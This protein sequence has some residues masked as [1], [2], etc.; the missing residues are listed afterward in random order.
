MPA[1]Q[2]RD[3][4]LD[5]YERLKEQAKRDRRSVSQEVIHFVETCL[6]DLERTDT[7][8]MH[9][10]TYHETQAA[11]LRHLEEDPEEIAKRAEKRRRLF[12]HIRARGPIDGID[13]ATLIREGRAER[14]R[15]LIEDMSFLTDEQKQEMF[16][17]LDAY[18]RGE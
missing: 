8:R 11:W 14:D 15:Q 13:G 7:F 12:E 18:V 6:D 9:G 2:V 3:F 5:V 10:R 16:A 1:L 17:E 4:P